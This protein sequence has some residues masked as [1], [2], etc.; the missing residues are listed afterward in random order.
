MING[1]KRLVSRGSDNPRL[2]RLVLMTSIAT[3]SICIPNTVAAYD[4]KDIARK[5]LQKT[6][7]VY[8]LETADDTY[9]PFDQIPDGSTLLMRPRSQK[10]FYDDDIYAIKQGNNVYL[11]FQDILNILNFPIQFSDNEQSANGWFIRE[12]WDFAINFDTMQVTSRGENYKIQPDD[13]IEQDG[14]EFIRGKTI[15][16]WFG[17]NF[18]YD[19]SQ[20]IVDIESPFPLP[21]VARNLRKKNSRYYGQRNSNDAQLP[22]LEQDRSNFDINSLD[23][24]LNTRYDRDTLGNTRTLQSGNVIAEGEILKHNSYI[25]TS[26]DNENGIE[27]VVTRFSKQSE[28][29]TLLGPLKARS[30]TFGDIN[31]ANIPLT[32][33]TG[34]DLGFQFD[35]NKLD[36]TDFASTDIEGD[37]IPG[38]DV[39]LYR[40]DVLIDN[41]EVSQNGR[42]SFNDIQLFIGSNNFELFFFG[43]QGEIRSEQITVPVSKELLASQNKTYDV[44][45]SFEDTQTYQQFQSNTASRNAL[46]LAARY[47]RLI[48]DSSL[49]Y[50]GVRTLELNGDREIFLSTGLSS[51]LGQTLLDTNF[52]VDGNGNLATEAIARRQLG[53]WDVSLRGRANSDEY[54]VSETLTPLKLEISLNAQRALTLFDD[55]RTNILASTRYTETVDG[56]SQKSADIGISNN[57]ARATVSNRIFYQESDLLT[58]GSEERLDHI[59]S[60]RKNFG[61]YFFRLGSTFS[62]RPDSQFSNLVGAVNYYHSNKFSTDF[63]VERQIRNDLNIA[64]INANYTNDKYRLSPFIQVD[65]NEA[66]Q[67][68]VNVNFALGDVPQSPF[69]E[70]TNRRL[71]GKGSVSAL[72][73]HDKNG[74]M[75]FDGDDEPLPEAIVES[76]NIR[77]RSAS[78]N[79]GYAIIRDLS[80]TRATDIKLDA[81]TLPDPFMIAATEGNSI[82]P[83]AGTM[84]EM[85][86]PVHMTG[87]VEGTVLYYN[88]ED[89]AQGASYYDV[90]LLSMDNPERAPISVRTGRDGYYVAFM[91]P[92]GQYL[93]VPQAK[94]KRFGNPIPQKI[95]IN[96]DGTILKDKD[97]VLQKGLSYVP[98]DVAFASDVSQILGGGDR[99]IKVKTGGGSG[100]S[101]TISRL[102]QK[103]YADDILKTL[104]PLQSSDAATTEFQ[105]YKTPMQSAKTYHDTCAALQAKNVDCTVVILGN[106]A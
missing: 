30:Y 96:Y 69:P 29:A 25:F 42:Y 14:F 22:R 50:I 20:Q 95:T 12:D 4:L 97:I 57:I 77:R 8:G 72:V 82:F 75:I 86:F 102:I 6:Q 49:G 43:P 91:L 44:S 90:T 21:T 35:N 55:Y 11:D 61:K 87:E 33:S 1:F 94:D 46:H 13:I 98:Y 31:I 32:G 88:D 60:L 100:L 52:A 78:N 62:I 59:F 93:M 103:K 2:F 24:N 9:N 84:Y 19:I 23:V 3:A 64:R 53:G 70:M 5:F 39:Q 17:I 76:M 54:N 15:A 7:S 58:G 85:E 47:N 80:P 79:D 38:W 27:N 10:I 92:P 83:Q 73:Y 18:S 67:A 40:N 16:D 34:Q 65:S 81:D 41:Q 68:G 89:I 56:T 37:S 104:E 26:G 63:T 74:N 36:N 99:V 105:Y 48:T 106:G 66:L 101:Q 28:D 45:M 71:S 51:T